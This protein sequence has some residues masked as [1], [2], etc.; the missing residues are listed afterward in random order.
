MK[1]SGKKI[2]GIILSILLSA[3][4]LGGCGSNVDSNAA[5][6]HEADTVIIVGASVSPHAEILKQAEGDLAKAGYTLKI[7]EFSDYV[8]P[9]TA[10]SE[11][12]LDANFFQHKPY[13]NDFNTENGTDIAAA[14]DIHFEP[15]GIYGGKTA[16]LSDI[17]EGATVAVPNDTTNEARA[18]LLLE[19]NGLI[20]LSK[21]AG[22]NATIL[23]IVENPLNLNIQEI[24]AEQLTRALED[25][26]IACINGNHA[27][28]GGLSLE[29]ALAV[30][31]ADSLAAE[32]YANVIAVKSGQEQS[33]KIQALIS[34]LQSDSIRQYIE[35]TWQDAV[36]PVF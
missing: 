9:N 35:E 34:A 26:D 12:D 21:E 16:S 8:L 11:G 19:A 31:T 25:V 4:V 5:A 29:D 13:L 28:N 33:A 17:Q 30:E 22:V 6:V 20:T 23:D 10:L 36:V 18:L 3:V 7:V 1:K 15:L 14:A 32:T 24:A 2:S 27:I